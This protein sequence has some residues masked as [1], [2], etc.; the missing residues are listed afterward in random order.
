LD[1]LN[2]THPAAVFW[3]GN[4]AMTTSNFFFTR[5]VLEKVG[6]FRALRYTHDWD[7]ALRAQETVGCH[8]IDEQLLSYRVHGSNTISEGNIWTH[9]AEN[10]FVFASMLKRSPLATQQ[11]AS[12]IQAP[13]I[14]G[15]ILRNESFL[16][17]PTLT[18]L[19]MGLSDEEMLADLASGNLQAIFQRVLQTSGIGFD[20]LLSTAHVQNLLVMGTDQNAGA[21]VSV[22][23]QRLSGL[24]KKA[25]SQV[26]RLISAV[27]RKR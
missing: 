3:V 14:L 24:A 11:E 2:K 16:P 22:T 5:S 19:A 7:W 1:L 27:G 26:H 17:L 18:L 8:R 25:I 10:A 12:Q 20:Q 15:Y 23:D 9:I 6:F 13:E 21:K 4:V